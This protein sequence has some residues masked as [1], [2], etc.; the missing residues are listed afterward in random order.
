MN[1]DALKA[2]HRAVRDGYQCSILFFSWKTECKI[3]IM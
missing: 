1:H 3:K 2:R